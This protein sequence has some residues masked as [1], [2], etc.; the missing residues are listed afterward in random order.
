MVQY[1]LEELRQLAMQLDPFEWTYL[2]HYA[3]EVDWTPSNSNHDLDTQ[4]AY[5]SHLRQRDLVRRTLIGDLI[6]LTDKGRALLAYH[7]G[8]KDHNQPL[9]H[10][11][12]P[13]VPSLVQQ[14]RQP[15]NPLVPGRLVSDDDT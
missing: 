11:G 13:P 2:Y 4:A 9:S 14:R 12:R 3:G 6:Q 5:Y 1:T 10:H 8:H 7:T 15:P